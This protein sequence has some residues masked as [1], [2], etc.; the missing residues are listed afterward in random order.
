MEFFRPLSDVWQDCL[1]SR[2]RGVRRVLIYTEQRSTEK[3]E[4]TAMRPVGVEQTIKTAQAINVHSHK[5]NYRCRYQWHFLKKGNTVWYKDD[6]S[7]GYRDSSDN[8][9]SAYLWNVGLL[10]RGYTAL[11]HRKLSLY[12]PPWEPEISHTLCYA[13]HIILL[14][15]LSV[16]FQADL[17]MVYQLCRSEA[18]R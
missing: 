5:K 14:T 17:I 13:M 7:L 8:G 18:K 4:H 11:Y 16:Y 10:Q 9:G 2:G 1:N 6:R 12:S 15:Q 3:R